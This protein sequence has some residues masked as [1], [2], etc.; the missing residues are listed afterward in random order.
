MVRKEPVGGDGMVEAIGLRTLD[1]IGRA[2]S[3]CSRFPDR[4]PAPYPATPRTHVGCRRTASI[5]L[6]A[7]QRTR[8]RRIVRLTATATGRFADG[9]VD[10]ADVEKKKCGLGGGTKRGQEK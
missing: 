9:S 3:F 5:V 8:L 4:I 2:N 7:E 6:A 1:S 10:E